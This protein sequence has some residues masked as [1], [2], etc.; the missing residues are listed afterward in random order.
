[1]PMISMGYNYS[2]TV[3]SGVGSDTGRASLTMNAISI[4]RTAEKDDPEMSKKIWLAKAIQKERLIG[5]EGR[6]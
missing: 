6:A 3:S 2:P 4:T 1:M 5:G